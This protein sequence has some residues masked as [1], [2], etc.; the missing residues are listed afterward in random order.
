[1]RRIG[2]LLVALLAGCATPATQPV[3]VD[4]AATRREAMKQQEIALQTFEEDQARLSRIAYPLVTKAVSLCGAE[5]RFVHGA[6]F[7]G[8]YLYKPEQRDAAQAAFGLGDGVQVLRV[9]PDSPAQRA[10]LQPGDEVTA[11]AGRP[12]PRGEALP[13]EL[14]DRLQALAGS[15]DE[16]A[17]EVRRDGAA[18]I[19]R[20]APEKACAFA[21]LLDGGD[22][23]NAFATGRAVAVTRGMLRFVRN[24]AELALVISHELAHN[25]MKHIEA[26]K[27][28]A[29]LGL[30]LDLAAVAARVDTRGAFS[31]VAGGAYSQEFEAEADYVG[32]YMMALAGQDI[33]DAPK[34]WR[35]MAALNPGS[36]NAGHSSSHPATAYRMVALEEAAKEI[37]QKI[38]RGAP[39]V[40]EMKKKPAARSSP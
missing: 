31:R 38:A 11:L 10:G 37:R 27:A 23:V 2:A 21:V 5:T 9:I 20:I 12:V 1:M 33:G 28:N 13:K 19:L 25:A 14:G 3:R 29:G 32:L 22:A 16:F 30:L 36:I 4:D 26:K 18:R 8:K 6:V 35:R 17:V 34:F 40:P 24:D 39:L 7:V 15:G